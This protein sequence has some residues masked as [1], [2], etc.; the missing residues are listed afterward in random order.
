MTVSDLYL[1][2]NF[3]IPFKSEFVD[4]K[5]LEYLIIIIISVWSVVMFYLSFLIC[6]LCLLSFPD[7]QEKGLIKY[8]DL[9]KSW[10]SVK[11]SFLCTLFCDERTILVFH[12]LYST[13]PL[14]S[15]GRVLAF[16]AFLSHW[17]VC[18]FGT[19]TVIR[20]CLFQSGVKLDSELVD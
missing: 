1:P 15:G 14:C 6:E 9:S 2:R 16:Y 12:E 20:L 7:F 4:M 18:L 3:P 5:L 10:F 19:T 17:T 11:T 13:D 8:T